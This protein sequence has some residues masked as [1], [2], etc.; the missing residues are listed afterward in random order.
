MLAGLYARSAHP[1]QAIAILKELMNIQA[2]TYGESNSI[3]LGGHIR[4]CRGIIESD[5]MV[6]ESD[7][8]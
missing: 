5:H 4:A 6:R 1:H 2:Q 7:G 8:H 3:C